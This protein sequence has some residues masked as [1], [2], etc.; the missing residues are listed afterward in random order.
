MVFRA[1]VGSKS[2]YSLRLPISFDVT[3]SANAI[4]AEELL[5]ADKLMSQYCTPTIAVAAVVAPFDD[6][7]KNL[8]PVY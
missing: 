3:S 1:T 5:M 7:R 6:Y 8:S 2:I 4:E